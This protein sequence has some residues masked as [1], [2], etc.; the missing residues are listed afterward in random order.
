MQFKNPEVLYL[1]FLLIIPI[2]IHLFQLQKFKKIAFSNVEFLQKIIKENR[3]SSQLKKLLI[4]ATRLLLLT[5]ILFTFSQPFLSNKKTN[6]KEVNFIYLDNSLSTNSIGSRGDLFNSTIKDLIENVSKNSLYSLYTNE[7]Y[8]ENISYENLK[9]YLLN[10]ENTANTP[11]LKSILLKAEEFKNNKI[12]TLYNNILISDFQNINYKMFTNVKG[13]F[14]TFLLKPSTK[15]NISIDS[16]YI[17]DKIDGNFSVEVFIKNQGESQDNIP[18]AFYND[19]KLIS[20]RTFS[21]EKNSDK[22]ISFSVEKTNKINGK[23]QI[24]LNDTF[25]FD[26]TFYF[27]FKPTKKNDILSI[28]NSN[29]FFKKIYNKSEFNFNHF[30]LNNIDYNSIENQELIILNELKVIPDILLDYI[31]KFVKNGGVVVV[32]PNSDINFNTYN[33]LFE[34]FSNFKID[35]KIKDSLRVTDINFDHPIFKNVFTDKI[36]NFQYPLVNEYFASNERNLKNIISLEN[37]K[38]FVGQIDSYNLFWVSS[39]LNIKATN[40][41]NSPLIVP[42]FY[43]F[44][45]LSNKGTSLFYRQENTDNITIEESLN[46]NEVLSISG[47]NLN[48]IPAQKTFQERVNISLENQTL[49][50]GFYSVLKNKDTI[51]TLALNTPKSESSLKFLDVSKITDKKINIYSSISELFNDINKKNEVHWLWKW[52]LSLAIVS[53]CVE[54]LILKFYK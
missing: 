36:K 6:K 19:D 32:I 41:S 42:T 17:N 8:I 1:L 54:I 44:G 35:N 23:I 2:L 39:P 46:K 5:A 34:K 51:K 48:F 26:N 28:G 18:V 43:N 13:D 30:N 47:K 16:L 31:E 14:S 10:L 3:K 37:E 45:K 33:K 53:L 20:K 25:K 27:N 38:S 7:K 52:F 12:N 50:P 49:A 9:S 4:L 40:F 24:T 11:N 21:I 22:K 29:I 15:F